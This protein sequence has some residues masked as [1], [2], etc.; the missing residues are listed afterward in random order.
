MRVL[1]AVGN[2][3]LWLL[4]ALGVASLLVW[5]AGKAGLLQP[6]VVVS[7]SMEPG[8]MTGD[9]L[10]DVRV[11]TEQVEVGDVV[12]LQSPINE[13]LVTH[14]V[15]AV[16]RTGEGTWGIRLKGDANDVEDGGVY[17]VGDHV[18]HPVLQLSGGGNVVA[19]L[20][21]PSVV[22][23]LGVT[24]LALVGLALMPSDPPRRREPDETQPDPTPT[25]ESVPTP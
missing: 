10:V 20:S 16:E 7:G 3:V 12:S 9:L 24:L 14:R 2:A 11:P 15:V 21:R 17:E 5:G 13:N 23:P 25:R 19:A 18:W 4:A 1:S 22:V 8:I 6:L